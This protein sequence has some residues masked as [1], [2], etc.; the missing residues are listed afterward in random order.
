MS[1]STVLRWLIGL[2]LPAVVAVAVAGS[3]VAAAPT[4]SVVPGVVQ[5][6]CLA[7]A[8]VLVAVGAERR[9]LVGLAD[10]GAILAMQELLVTAATATQTAASPVV[11]VAVA[12][13]AVAAAEQVPS[14]V[15]VAAV[16]ATPHLMPRMSRRPLVFDLVMVM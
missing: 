4:Q 7:L 10:R 15:A 1:G 8:T 12:G 11:A 9:M 6:V 2:W 5:R 3:A 13:S 16:P 14:A